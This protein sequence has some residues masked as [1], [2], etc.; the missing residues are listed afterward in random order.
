ME[1]GVWSVEFGVWSLEFGVWSVERGVWSVECGV[2]SVEWRWDNDQG[3][4]IQELTIGDG[5]YYKL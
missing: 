4:G 2:W 3:A 5:Y 1:R